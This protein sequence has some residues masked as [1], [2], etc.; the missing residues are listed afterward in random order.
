MERTDL[1]RYDKIPEDMLNYLRYN[2]PHFNKKLCDFA[3]SKMYKKGREKVQPYTREHVNE[4]LTNNNVVVEN[5]ILQ[6]VLFVANMCK[7]DYLGSS[8]QTEAQVA[9]FIRD[10]LDDPDGYDGIAFN[11]WYADT[12]RLGIVIDWEEML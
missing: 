5:N 2:G 1:T 6:D 10:Y 9:K 4:I 8:I 3:V 11:R 12:C 7:A